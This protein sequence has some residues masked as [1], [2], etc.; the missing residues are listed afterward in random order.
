LPIYNQ[1]SDT[2]VYHENR[3]KFET[4][5]KQLMLHFKRKLDR[6]QKR[7]TF[8]TETYDKLMQEWLKRMETKD[9]NPI[10]KTKE[11]KMREFFEKQFPELRKQRE[12]KERLCR[13]GQRVRSDA[14]LEDIMDGL[15]EQELE[16]KKIRAYAVIPP[17]LHDPRERVYR[18][19]TSN[20]KIDDPIDEYKEL[21]LHNVWTDSEKE[22][23]KEKFL[24]APKNFGLIA[25]YLERKSVMDCVQYYY[26]SKKRENYKQL[27]RKNAKKRTRALAKAQQHAAQQAAQQA[28]AAQQQLQQQQEL[29]RLAQARHLKSSESEKEN[30]SKGGE[31]TKVIGQDS[32]DSREETKNASQAAPATVATQP[33]EQTEEDTRVKCALCIKP[34][35]ENAKSYALSA[36]NCFLYAISA[37]DVRPQARVCKPCK[38][39]FSTGQCPVPGCRTPDK[40]N[41]RLRALPRLWFELTPELRYTYSAELNFPLDCKRCCSRC[42]VRL[43]RKCSGSFCQPGLLRKLLDIS[44]TESDVQLLKDALRKHGRNWSSVANL[45]QSSKTAKQC[46]DF[47]FFFKYELRLNETLRLSAFHTPVDSDSESYWAGQ[48]GSDAESSDDE[49]AIDA[50]TLNTNP[51]ASGSDTNSG[52]SSTASGS[53]NENQSNKLQDLKR[54]SSSQISL[55][56]DCDSSATMSAD[57][58]QGAGDGEL[59]CSPAAALGQPPRSSSAFSGDKRLPIDRFDADLSKL[60]SSAAGQRYLDNLLAQHK[61]RIPS[62]LINP[63]A[64]T[65]PSNSQRLMLRQDSPAPNLTP[66]LSL[67]STL[68]SMTPSVQTLPTTIGGS[69]TSGLPIPTSLAGAAGGSGMPGSAIISTGLNAS[70]NQNLSVSSLQGALTTGLPNTLP[71]GLP[72]NLSNMPTNLTTSGSSSAGG[73]GNNSNTMMTSSKEKPTCVRDLIYQAIEISLQSPVK[74]NKNDTTPST[75]NTTNLTQSSMGLGPITA[76]IS[77][78][79]NL[80]TAHLS[81][82]AI[83]TKANE[84]IR[85]HMYLHGDPKRDVSISLDKSK[86]FSLDHQAQLLRNFTESSLSNASVGAHQLLQQQQQQLAASLSRPEGLAMMASYV[87]LNQ[88]SGH[89]LTSHVNSLMPVSGIP[90]L[91]PCDNDNEVQ[92]LSKKSSVKREQAEDYNQPKNYS[93]PKSKDMLYSAHVNP[94]G[95]MPP[96]AH[97]NQLNSRTSTPVLIDSPGPGHQIDPLREM[98]MASRHTDSP[99][100]MK[101]QMTG[102]QRGTPNSSLAAPSPSPSPTSASGSARGRTPTAFAMMQHQVQQVNAKHSI[103]PPPP[104]INN[105]KQAPSPNLN[106]F[107]PKGHSMGSASNVGV[108]M[109]NKQLLLGSITQGT[110]IHVSTPGSIGPYSGDIRYEGLLRPSSISRDGGSITLGTPLHEAVKRKATDLSVSKGDIN[111]QNVPTSLSQ[112]MKGALNLLDPALESYYR[113]LSPSAFAGAAVA[114]QL[115]FNL[116]SAA[117]A[118]AAAAGNPMINTSGSFATPTGPPVTSM[119][120]KRFGPTTESVQNLA[121]SQNQ[122]LIDFNTSKQMQVNRRQSGPSSMSDKEQAS[123]VSMS[124]NNKMELPRTSNAGMYQFAQGFNPVNSYV[125]IP[126]Q[127]GHLYNTVTGEIREQSVVEAEV[128]KHSMAAALNMPMNFRQNVIQQHKQNPMSNPINLANVRLSPSPIVSAASNPH[129]ISSMNHQTSKPSVI[130]T[131]INLQ[132]HQSSAASPNQ[133]I[134]LKQLTANSMASSIPV[135][136]NPNAHNVSSSLVSQ[137]NLVNVGNLSTQ[138]GPANAS[139]L[140]GSI[141][142]QSHDAFQALVNAAAAQKS[143]AVPTSQLKS[144]GKDSGKGGLSFE[145][146]DRHAALDFHQASSKLAASMASVG[147]TL[148]LSVKSSSAAD[149]PAPG[150]S[151]KAPEE[152]GKASDDNPIVLSSHQQQPALRFSRDPFSKEQFEKEFKQQQQQQQQ[153]GI[154]GSSAVALDSNAKRA[155]DLLT[156]RSTK[157]A[158]SS[159]SNEIDNEA[160]RIFSDSFQKDNKLPN[161]GFT[162]ANLIDAIITHQINQFENVQPKPPSSTSSSSLNI[163]AVK[164]VLNRPMHHTD[165]D[166]SAVS[167]LDSHAAPPMA[168][169]MKALHFGKADRISSTDADNWK[170]RKVLEQNARP[171]DSGQ[172]GKDASKSGKTNENLLCQPTSASNSASNSATVNLSTASNKPNAPSVNSL[173][174][175]ESTLNQPDN[176]SSLSWGPTHTLA[177]GVMTAGP[178]SLGKGISP[179]DYVKNRI[180]EVM[181]SSSD[182]KSVEEQKDAIRSEK[183]TSAPATSAESRPS[184]LEDMPTP[185]KKAR[186]NESGDS[187]ASDTTV[188]SIPTGDALSAKD[189]SSSIVKISSI[190]VST[191][192]KLPQSSLEC[193]TSLS[194]LKAQKA[195][196]QKQQQ[197]KQQQQQQQQQSQS[198]EPS[199]SDQSSQSNLTASN[200]HSDAS[201]D[202]STLHSSDEKPSTGKFNLN[203][204]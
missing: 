174:S 200:L 12:D 134:N 166:R 76:S 180:V 182:E 53:K 2:L 192:T 135:S 196:F 61:Q 190:P 169:Q 45:I 23:F 99:R 146:M 80:S 188:P 39:K 48:L 122:L 138:S 194:E 21:Q 55:K 41:R 118:A 158:L 193:I 150:S 58:G 74:G 199:N 27:L 52:A 44:W 120:G 5:K 133:A 103:P 181:R 87:H 172:T 117:A 3:S 98:Y 30:L 60:N 186:I 137:N 162:A 145:T 177:S 106:T 92:D 168:D 108:N 97:S 178:N 126:G 123:P 102:D 6:K 112:N 91:V 28:A 130:Q 184:D 125:P 153:Q 4:F 85:Q 101:Q 152:D 78:P 62:F 10:K 67:A 183:E 89:P 155:S 54:L 160:S 14:D 71:S 202:H 86:Q 159:N 115:P 144:V 88:P 156:V 105:A 173:T 11:N 171:E 189:A 72:A 50:L 13:A 94:S 51:D 170:L 9:F 148:D 116:S 198:N 124:L 37:D 93:M 46:R 141:Y 107:S 17:I 29:Q 81:N 42:W 119:S 147:G 175:S 18:F 121:T 26:S 185:K 63:N 203:Q 143:L 24:Q 22:V 34:I 84:A 154:V 111:F 32:P 167:A 164:P 204:F 47:Y 33:I 142:S 127:P 104:L 187:T 149:K 114:A 128:S 19:I 77:S 16:D 56:S 136:L 176:K 64:P 95:S 201:A 7:E 38:I 1:P 75:A 195:E 8:L 90:L 132:M 161:R 70:L 57:E 65:V 43:V 83:T 36:V 113:R 151:K 69:I 129:L 73:A 35:E 131:P 20:C 15:Q 66:S 82:A 165:Q 31:T 68:A 110:P 109:G 140:P 96:P 100:A 25:S 79:A 157:G 49:Y 40:Q 59:R 197:L 163:P 139:F 191:S 179:F